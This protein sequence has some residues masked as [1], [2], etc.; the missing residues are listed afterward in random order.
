MQLVTFA[1]YEPD[2]RLGLLD[3]SRVLDLGAAATARDG[4]AVDRGDDEPLPGGRR[5]Q[6]VTWPP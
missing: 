1:T 3:G 6:P 2:G 5:P 4:D